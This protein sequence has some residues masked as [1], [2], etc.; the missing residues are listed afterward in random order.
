MNLLQSEIK[1]VVMIEPQVFGDERGYFMET[2]SQRE[3]QK[4]GV[5]MEFV[6]DN[7]SRSVQGTLRGLHYQLAPHSQGKLGRVIQGVV[8]DAAVDIRKSSPT[9]KKWVGVDG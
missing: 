3:F 9:F 2:Y 8:F 1:D 4:L 5:S 6:Q 7:M